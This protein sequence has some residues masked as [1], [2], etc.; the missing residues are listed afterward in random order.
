M[1][2]RYLFERRAG[3]ARKEFRERCAYID[4]VAELAE[5]ERELLKEVERLKLAGRLGEL[6]Q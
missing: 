5:E 1:L 4:G 6:L 2:E 3:K